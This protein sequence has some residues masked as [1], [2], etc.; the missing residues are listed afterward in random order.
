MRHSAGL[1]VKAKSL[2]VFTVCWKRESGDG[3]LGN[4]KRSQKFKQL[5]ADVLVPLVRPAIQICTG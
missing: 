5:S 4:V 1:A 2:T 3:F